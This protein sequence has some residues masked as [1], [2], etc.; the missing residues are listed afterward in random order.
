MNDI[1]PISSP[2]HVASVVSRRPASP[3][4]DTPS[5][6]ITDQVEIS[7]EAQLLNSLEASGEIRLDKVAEIRQKIQQG[8]YETAEK[9]EA[10]V[11]RL[12]EVLKS[13]EGES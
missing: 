3:A 5:S 7:D 4:S 6:A 11:E 2:G 9:I 12:L 8:T 1:P 10:T 13:V